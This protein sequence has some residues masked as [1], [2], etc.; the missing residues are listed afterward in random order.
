MSKKGTSFRTFSLRPITDGVARRRAGLDVF[1]VAAERSAGRDRLSRGPPRARH[2]VC[3]GRGEGRRGG[4]L[5]PT[6]L[7]VRG[8]ECVALVGPSGSG[9]STLISCVA[10]LRVASA[11]QVLVEGLSLARMTGAE[12]SSM[13]RS[14]MGMVFQDADLLDELDVQGNVALRLVFDAVRRR[15]ALRDADD[16][17]RRDHLVAVQV[18]LRIESVGRRMASPS[19][20]TLLRRADIRDCMLPT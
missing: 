10:G 8:G 11:G 18:A 19:P 5:L 1:V 3:R 6:S 7:S 20:R 15:Q 16:L 13:R 9:K 17:L 14:R 4:L 12:R 2:R